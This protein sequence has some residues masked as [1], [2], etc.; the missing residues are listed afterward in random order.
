MAPK[1]T[2]FKINIISNY[3]I[4]SIFASVFNPFILPQHHFN[5]FWGRLLLF[6]STPLSHLLSNLWYHF[7]L[8]IHLNISLPVP[9]IK[10]PL[11]NLCN[12]FHT[13]TIFCQFL[14]NYLLPFL[15]LSFFYFLFRSFSFFLLFE[16]TLSHHLSILFIRK[17]NT[18][19]HSFLIP[20][21]FN[22][23]RF[24]LKNSF[25]HSS[26]KC[27]WFATTS[28]HTFTCS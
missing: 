2:R 23:L 27:A 15:D 28:S 9:S 14:K 1:C 18:F 24:C 5:I 22:L 19:L 6:L 20:S 25:Q 8:P 26:E 10:S 21:F 16:I 11:S 13:S 7:L 12:H 4:S 17:Q 3:I